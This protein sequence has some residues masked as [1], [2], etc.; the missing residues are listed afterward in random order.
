MPLISLLTALILAPFLRSIINKV[1]AFFAGKQGPPL[2][3]PYYDLYK[4][5]RKGAVYSSV[6][7]WVF[8]AGPVV[9]LGT[10]VTALIL[11]PTARISSLFQFQGDLLLFAYILGLGRFFTIAAAMDTG[12]SFE[13]MGASREALYSALAEPGLLLGLGG[14]G[15]I[16]RSISLS[17][18]YGGINVDFVLSRGLLPAFLFILVAFFIILL[19]ENSRI[20]V[21]D[22]TT[23]LE[24][25]M[26]HEVMILDHCGVDLAM[27]EYAG[28]LKIWLMGLLITGLIVP[29]FTTSLRGSLALSIVSLF[30]MAMLIGII[31]SI[32]A[33]LK[34]I[35]IP[36][37]MAVA[38]I[39]AAFWVIWVAG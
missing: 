32:M 19:A 20:P 29:V 36:R 5:S 21:D 7:S 18:M 4:L 11:M 12:S 39:F 9:A 6:T 27:I 13:G 2:L 22:P 17:A 28:A 1:K 23:H 3:Q 33:R 35:R 8:R 26:I 24:L 25:T 34:L 30:L 14:L 31:E 10:S 16:T 37:L 38:F 15:L